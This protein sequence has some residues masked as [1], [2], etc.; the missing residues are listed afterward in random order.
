MAVLPLN[1]AVLAVD[2][3]LGS[4]VATDFPASVYCFSLRVKVTA[5]SFGP[6]T[7]HVP[8]AI[9]IRHY[10]V[11]VT[12]TG[13]L[14]LELVLSG[15][16]CSACRLATSLWIVCARTPL[17]KGRPPARGVAFRSGSE[18]SADARQGS[19]RLLVSAVVFGGL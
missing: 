4:L 18:I 3:E 10:V 9:W 11:T 2:D 7:L 13:D 17:V 14:M 12:H 19:L 16:V 6:G 15:E 8:A 5:G 1:R